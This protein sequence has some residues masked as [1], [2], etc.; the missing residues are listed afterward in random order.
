MDDSEKGF[1]YYGAIFEAGRFP[2]LPE[3]SR[4]AA[5]KRKTE[6]DESKSAIG[7]GSA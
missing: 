3:S 6:D 1:A 2:F 7:G 5:K 4:P